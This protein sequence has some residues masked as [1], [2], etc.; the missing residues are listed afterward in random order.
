MVRIEIALPGGPLDAGLSAELCDAFGLKTAFVFDFP[1][2]AEGSLRRRLGEAAGHVLMDTITP[3]DVLSLSWAA[4][5]GELAASLT[6]LPPCT[7]I[8]LTGA[9][10]PVGGQDLLEL[11]RS[12][13]RVGGGTAHVF[14]APM[15]VADAAAATVIR[16]QA[17]VANTL[18]L[19]PSST[20]AM[21]AINA[22]EPRRSPLY[23]ACSPE[24]RLEIARLGVCGEIAGI[25]LEPDGNPVPTSLDKRMLITPAPVLRGI[26]YVVAVAYG[27]SSTTAVRA[28]TRSGIIK[29]LVTHTS[30]A[31]AL[32][33]LAQ[34]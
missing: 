23:E 18:A 15:V 6:R 26:P 5:M 7:V 16:R 33:T 4:S 30:L 8:Q 12:V 9:V 24:E 20:I 25:F 13:A 10:P 32:L 3:D 22:W 31:R 1:D 34:Q 19:V 27:E 21:V 2:N 11:V 28:A 17:D 14:Y 29:G